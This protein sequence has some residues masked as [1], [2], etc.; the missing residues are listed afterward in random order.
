MPVL[1]LV[2]CVPLVSS[3]SVTVRCF[4]IQSLSCSLHICI[5]SQSTVEEVE[6]FGGM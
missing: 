4:T 5:I 1:F 3:L 2:N 6:V